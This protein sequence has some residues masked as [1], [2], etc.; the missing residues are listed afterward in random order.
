MK[1]KDRFYSKTIGCIIAMLAIV[2]GISSCKDDFTTDD[3][4]FA[5][6][7]TSMTDIGPSMAGVIASPTY[8]GAAPYD[9]K[10]TGVTYSSGDVS[11][12]YNGECFT[13]NS[14]T[15]E[16]YINSTKDMNVGKYILS[17][18][19]QSAGTLY[20]FPNAVE[21]NFLKAVPEGIK[22]TP[23]LLE[24][25]LSDVNNKN[26]ETIFPTAQV[27]TE[28]TKEH[29]TITGYKISNVV[30]VGSDDSETIINN[31]KINLFSVSDAGVISI[32]KSD[33]YDMT[34]VKA[35]TY[36]ID[37]KLTTA[38]S[39][40]L[41]EEDGLFTDALT[42]NFTDV[43]SAI[44]YKEGTI[45]TGIEGD[46]SKPKGAFTSSKPLIEG[47]SINA[48]YE[49]T[50]IKKNSDGTSDFADA[51]EAEKAF[52]T[53]DT[54]T[55]II[56]VPN[57]HTFKK[58]DLFKISVKVI[59]PYGEFNGTDALTLKVIDWMDPLADFTYEVKEMKQGMSYIS[60]RPQGGG[61]DAATN[62]EYS[63]VDMP[64]EYAE[65]FSINNAT[66]EVSVAKYNT[67]PQG[68]FEVTVKAKNFKSEAQGKLAINVV[69]NP[70]YFTYISYGNN[71]VDDQTPGSIYDNQFRF[72]SKEAANLM[73]LTPR[74]DCKEGANVTWKIS[75][76]TQYSSGKKED[77]DYYEFITKDDASGI[78]TANIRDKDWSTGEVTLTT[79]FVTATVGSGE[80]AYSRTFPLFIN[81]IKPYKI[82]D[83]EYTVKYTPFVLR[84]NP[85][86]GGRS[87]VPEI[88][89]TNKFVLDYR[90]SFRYDNINGTD[91]EGADLV[92]GSLSA[93]T[94]NNLLGDLW[95]NVGK[96]TNYGAKLPMSYFQNNSNNA[97]M[98][99][100]LADE[101]ICYVD[102]ASG[103]NQFS[104]VVTRNWYNDGWADGVFTGQMT[105][106]NDGTP[107]NVSNS[108][109]KIFPIAIWLDK[110][111]VSAE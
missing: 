17:I 98:P 88:S 73:R 38:A 11:E 106:S 80:D 51:S 40:S 83:V 93:S 14:E 101:T 111:Y 25:K 90:R 35:G 74:I 69:E 15:G 27:T 92:S 84:V 31:N 94:N 26:S 43:P 66:G 54:A 4:S 8:K 20:T 47:S 45:E 58:G 70:N 107:K 65:Y 52:F 37:L 22:V 110:S 104:V 16:I 21:V 56:S 41:A 3:G 57:T 87:V 85:K 33:E 62:V 75:M 18:S 36:K 102:N 68:A 103:S 29:I 53:I 13:I 76:K 105:F 109:C 64:E 108:N 81:Y 61:L 12:T 46:A 39:S 49:I 79:I 63:F 30:R 7:Y 91:S 32:N 95:R 6:Y 2:L 77:G 23:D 97:K 59:N 19:C 24:V 89:N 34:V 100:Q 60:S 72:E 99:T 5:L 96:S 55:G 10:I 78:I 28:N 1:M 71:L 67:L 86:Q 82:G 50:G 9:F 42:V 44:S 48:T